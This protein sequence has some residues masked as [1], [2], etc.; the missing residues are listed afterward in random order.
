MQDTVLKTVKNYDMIQPGDTVLCAVSGGADSVALLRVMLE[1][2]GALGITVCACHLNHSLRGAEAVRDENFVRALCEGLQ[3]P[4]YIERRDVQDYADQHGQGVEEAARDVRYDFF[5]EAAARLGADKVATAHT[6]DDN[7]ETMLFY[8][9]R[10]AGTR[11]MGGIPPVRRGIIRPF[12]GSTRSQVESYLYRINQPYVNDSSNDSSDYTRNRIRREV[13][14]VLRELNPRAAEAAGRT[15]HL[16]R[17]DEAYLAGRADALREAV[18]ARAPGGYLL[19]CRDVMEAPAA[20]RG[21]VLRGVLRQAGMP[22]GECTAGMVRQV[23][24]LAAGGNPSATLH[25]P[26]RLVAERRYGSLYIGAPCKGGDGA[27]IALYDGFS[28]PL[29]DTG[30]KLTVLRRKGAQDFN[31]TFNT[32][33]VDCGKIDFDTLCVRTRRQGDALRPTGN[34]GHRTLKRLMIDRKIPRSQRGRLGVVADRDG[35]IAVQSVGMDYDRK[36][37]GGPVLEIRFE[38]IRE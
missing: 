16:L 24:A 25:L 35:V 9:A 33:Y 13:V 23:I 38:G 3:V 2:R 5:R 31:K 22:M 26:G 27:E 18:A 14:P 34:G 17:Q 4:F 10:G 37:G 28:A 6:L 29:W 32:F 19:E 12:I 1:I 36:P 20:L 15:A 7:L 8:L 11:G 21:R 30:T